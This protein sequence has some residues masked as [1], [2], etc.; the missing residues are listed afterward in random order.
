MLE[1]GEEMELLD[2][3]LWWDVEAVM[4]APVEEP[5]RDFLRAKGY[6]TQWLR[7]PTADEKSEARGRIMNE[8]GDT[9]QL[10]AVMGGVERRNRKWED[11]Y[12]GEEDDRP[13]P[14]MPTLE[15]AAEQYVGV[16]LMGVMQVYRLVEY[17]ATAAPERWKAHS[18]QVLS[19]YVH[20]Q[21]QVLYRLRR[22]PGS[23]YFQF[24]NMVP[25]DL[26]PGDFVSPEELEA[27]LLALER[28]GR[29]EGER[30][31]LAYLVPGDGR[32]KKFL[33]FHTGS[34]P[35]RIAWGPDAANPLFDVKIAAEKLVGETGLREEDA[36][37]FLL[38]NSEVTLPWL[39]LNIVLDNS[40][41][42]PRFRLRIG[43][44]HVPVAEVER[45]YRRA[46]EYALGEM[47]SPE[48]YRSGVQVF[49]RDF[50]QFLAEPPRPRG[51]QRSAR[52]M[53]MAFVED[54]RAAGLSWQSVW[55]E[56]NAFAPYEAFGS[57]SILQ[58]VYYRARKRE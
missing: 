12:L 55:E 58:N 57:V 56:W 18:R 42:G 24:S 44:P 39:D 34:Q 32:R 40:V 49:A 5:L 3:A 9:R 38:C 36:V 2:E 6:V 13:M 50:D 1:G 45:L 14:P 17:Q 37:A 47:H 43:S 48:N 8:V 33:E 4:E 54:M 30:D 46:R 52:A 27:C 11:E 26:E 21:R 15:Q 29:Q 16:G 10:M 19:R 35:G 20:E 31:S 25:K 28:D 51:T 22:I 41:R 23:K 53:L 7:A